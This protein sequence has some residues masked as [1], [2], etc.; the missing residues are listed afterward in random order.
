MMTDEEVLKEAKAKIQSM[1]IKELRQ[2]VAEL[3]GVLEDNEY[4]LHLLYDVPN[5]KS[6]FL[7]SLEQE[8]K[9]IKA[10]LNIAED[11]LTLAEDDLYVE[12]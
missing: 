8:Q 12:H 11:E 2:Q 1:N 9:L 6:K 5:I 4:T 10:M 7:D 3:F